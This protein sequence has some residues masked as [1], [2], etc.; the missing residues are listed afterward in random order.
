MQARHG[1][2]AEAGQMPCK[3]VRV[4]AVRVRHGRAGANLGECGG[5][6]EAPAAE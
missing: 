2:R 4:A 3:V 6:V 5:H 1:G